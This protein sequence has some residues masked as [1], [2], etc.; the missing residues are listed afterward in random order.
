MITHGKLIVLS[1][2]T[3]KHITKYLY[4]VNRDGFRQYIMFLN[5]FAQV[6]F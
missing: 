1:A 6:I 2:Y 4:F 5:L 3:F